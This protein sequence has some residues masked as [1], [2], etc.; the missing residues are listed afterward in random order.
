MLYMYK[1]G[2]L[3]TSFFLWK[4]SF[5]HLYALSGFK[6]N[7]FFKSWFEVFPFASLIHTWKSK[8]LGFH[9]FKRGKCLISNQEKNWKFPFSPNLFTWSI[10]CEKARY[11]TMYNFQKHFFKYLQFWDTLMYNPWYKFWKVMQ[12]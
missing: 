6:K 3:I 5:F 4:Y 7:F 10:I 11:D 12:R 9:V 8:I 1:R 2:S